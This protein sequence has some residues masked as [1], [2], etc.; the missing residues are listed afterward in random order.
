MWA[1]LTLLALATVAA[2]AA[3]APVRTC[4]RVEMQGEAG[5]GQ[6][7]KAA[8]GQG[9]VFRVLPIAPPSAGYSGWDLLVD[10]DPPAGYPDALLVA[11]LPYNSINQREI[12]TTFGLRAQDAIGWNPRSFHFLTNPA[13]FRQAQQW[14]A[15]LVDSR[16][17]TNSG[18]ANTVN[19][20]LTQQLLSLQKNASSG[21]LRILDARLVPGA[22]DP[23]PFAH[24]WA[25]AFSRTQHHIEPVAA[26]Q[27]S[28]RGK[29][30]WMRFA[31]TLWLPS[32]W[33][34]PI[35]IKPARVPCP[36]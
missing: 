14:L 15:Q 12:G 25:F 13:E 34:F 9:W 22:A 18:A 23:Q 33:K 3:T 24:A 1:S 6:E 29:L 7:W 4:Q 31:V 8:I 2:Q 17:M 28:P 10:R 27:A 20:R 21:Q 16:S 32:A 36:E 11:T 26:G 5:A 35:G 30:V 19:S